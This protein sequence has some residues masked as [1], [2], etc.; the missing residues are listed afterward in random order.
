MNAT[1]NA[2][3]PGYSVVTISRKKEFFMIPALAQRAVLQFNAHESHTR[4]VASEVTF[5]QTS[6][7]KS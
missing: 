4:E 3:G 7:V 5:T 1:H 6:R 2:E